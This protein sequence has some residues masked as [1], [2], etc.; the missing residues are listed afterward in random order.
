ME[1]ERKHTAKLLVLVTVGFLLF[2]EL[3]RLILNREVP[4]ADFNLTYR[5]IETLDKL[6]MNGMLG[7]FFRFS[8]F[9]I[10]N[11][12]IL[13]FLVND[14][15]KYKK[16]PNLHRAFLFMYCGILLVVG[17]KGYFNPRYT[18]TLFPV[19]VVYLL[20][21][22][23]TLFRRKG[24]VIY[25]KWVP[26]VLAFLAIYD[27]GRK[28]VTIE[29]YHEFMEEHLYSQQYKG[30]KN[31][32]NIEMEITRV[33]AFQGMVDAIINQNLADYKYNP[34][35]Y[36]SYPNLSQR[37]IFDFIQANY[38]NGGK[39]VLTNNIPAIYHNTEAYAVFYWCG[40]D[41]VYDGDGQWHLFE[42]RTQEEVKSYLL[43]TMD[44]GFIYTYEPY[45]NYNP[46][47]HEFLHD[48][49]KIIEQTFNTYQLFKIIE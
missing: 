10:I 36:D 16:L 46:E 2:T 40:E 37:K 1:V 22:L 47:F 49:C 20:Y 17:I 34:D 38:E 12:I 39:R 25:M 45:N 41:I 28:I 44:V 31:G 43:D 7:H 3:L 35:F 27:F 18:L 6:I 29:P 9:G 15:L 30:T 14:L 26:F 23:W 13:P 19:S 48:E 8:V 11:L 42:G 5:K 4:G 21:S 32:V 24:W 33:T